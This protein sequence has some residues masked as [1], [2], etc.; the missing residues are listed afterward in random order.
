[1]SLTGI[2]RFEKSDLTTARGCAREKWQ[3]VRM[4]AEGGRGDGDELT[5]DL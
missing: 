4:G 3:G 1:M 2:L 5:G